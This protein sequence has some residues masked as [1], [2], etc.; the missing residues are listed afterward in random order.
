MV[1]SRVPGCDE[2]PIQGIVVVS[3]GQLFAGANG[4]LGFAGGAALAQKHRVI[5]LCER[6][7]RR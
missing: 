4:W 2:G 6:A 7:D 5:D 1:V 3:A